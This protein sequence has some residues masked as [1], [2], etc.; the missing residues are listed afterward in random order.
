MKLTSLLNK[1]SAWESP[2]QPFWKQFAY[3]T[4]WAF[5]LCV[6]FAE[7]AFYLYVFG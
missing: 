6:L 2:S 4:A 3:Y 5:V 1:F 7:L